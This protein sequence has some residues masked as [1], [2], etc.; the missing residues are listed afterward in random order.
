MALY[1]KTTPS[2][3][4]GTPASNFTDSSKN[5]RKHSNMYRKTSGNET[6]SLTAVPGRYTDSTRTWRRIR[7]MYRWTGSTWQRI[8][9]KNANQPFSI[10]SATIRYDAYLGTIVDTYTSD[11]TEWWATDPYQPQWAQMGP[12]PLGIGQSTWY[13]DGNG[14][15]VGSSNPTYLWGRDGLWANDNGAS[16][17]ASFV[18]NN[19]IYSA[20]ASPSTDDEGNY[21]GDKLRNNES[22]MGTYDGYY[23]WYKIS[24]TVNSYTG[25]AFSQ[26]VYVTKQEPVINSFT[27]VSPGTATVGTA[28]TVTYSFSN[29]WWRSIDRYSSYIEWHELSYSTQTPDSSTLKATH[30]IYSTTYGTD[31]ATTF[32]GTDSYTPV[33]SNKYIYAKIVY[34]NTWTEFP[35]VTEKYAEVVTTVATQQGCGPFTL[36]NATKGQRYYDAGSSSWKRTVTVDIGKSEGADRYELQIRGYGPN[37]NGEYSFPLYSGYT[38]LLTYDASPYTM[39]SN[40]SG[41]TLTATA[42]VADYKYYEI[43]AR[44]KFGSTT[45]G[46]VISTNT[47]YPPEVAP[48]APVISSIS[49]STDFFGTYIT[50]NVYQSSLGSNT[51]KRYEYSLNGG[52]FSS[53]SSGTYGTLGTG[54]I[55][56]SNGVK[57]YVNEGTYYTL[58]IRLINYDDATSSS[59]NSLSITSAA[60]PSAPTSV[61]VKSFNA[62]QGTIFFTSG[63][64][65]QS[66]QGY[67]EY[68]SFG[69]TDSITNYVNVGSNTASKIQLTGAN[70]TTRSYTSFLRPYAGANQTG[71]TGSITTYSTKV[72]NGSDNMQVSLGTP[73]RP[74]DR[75]LSLSWTLSAGSPTHYVCRLYNY[76][77]GSLISTKTVSSSTTSISFN[78]SD[79]VQ[80]S[81]V[82]YIGVQPQYQYTSSVTYEDAN[83]VSSQINSGANLTAPT[84]TSIVSMTRLDDNNC[85]A[86]IS[87]SGGS[88]PYY[89]LFW[90]SGTNA[91]ITD[92]Y[93]AAGN[94]STVTEDYGFTSGITYYFYMR[95]S[96][97]NLGN[98]TTNGFGTDG[99][100]S[101]YGPSSGAASYSFAAPS[102]QTASISGSTSVG[103]TLTLTTSA[104]GS[105]TPTAS[106]IWRR[107]SGGTGGNSFTNG[108]VMQTGGMTYVIDSPVVG[109]SSVGYQ[110]RAEV[111]YNNGLGTTVTAY[112][113]AITVTA[114]P[115]APSNTSEPTLSPTSLSVGTTLTAGV[116][117]WSGTTPITYDLRIYRGTANVSTGETLVK[118]GGNVTSTTYTI[119]QA[120]YDSGQR[121]FKTYVSASNSGGS[122]GFVGGQERGPITPAATVPTA[123][124]NLFTSNVSSSGATINWSAP[125]SDGGAAITRY[126]VNRDGLS[127]FNVGNVN[128]YFYTL[129]QGTYTIGVRAVNSVGAGPVA[130]VSVTIPAAF[131]APTAPAPSW[132]SGSNFSRRTTSP[133]HLQ[134]FTDYPGISGSG[135]IT[136]MDFEIRTT[137]GGGTLLASGTRSYPG[138]GSYPYSAGGTIWAFRMGT[139]DGDITY[140]AASR[141]GRVRVRML[142][143]NGT[144]YFGTWSGWI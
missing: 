83:Y 107:A 46:S 122:T 84:S 96:T 79:G 33:G 97:E 125:S 128:Q 131:V 22:V 70:S 95:S 37:V 114:A 29:K 68:D 71:G 4:A 75:T 73:T 40:R 42:N 19:E 66:V 126:E 55:N 120:D 54:Y 12:G 9:Y 127:F 38:T 109:F 130:T 13:L 59:S 17:S 50:A 26:A 111:S 72:L 137:A 87:S 82:Y 88:G 119:T 144:T 3:Y 89:Q 61:V 133:T 94:T 10:E 134:W 47:L 129:S 140:N 118:S 6:A 99:T 57:L 2:S 1:R 62:S 43:T 65:T 81:T 20:G 90:Y 5:W 135:T 21:Q 11:A 98:T 34:K 115:V 141:F 52:S 78:S 74:S 28:K 53:I 116:G 123:P 143:S 14:N 80:Y 132:T 63:A 92:R 86:V 136:G 48:S 93:D 64:N 23:I 103:S 102:G 138:A 24:K 76:S 58:A 45:D 51:E 105:P 104:N 39:E 31:N 15:E 30:P 112:S 8:F 85:R 60:F 77:S 108:S 110:I 16:I 106:I 124:T 69:A 142:G 18:Y 25:T 41:G 32:S 35:P 36:S 56:A 44:A 117:T 113:N 101:A 67:L 49:T 100:Y 7:A 121:Y 27:M 139:T 91:P